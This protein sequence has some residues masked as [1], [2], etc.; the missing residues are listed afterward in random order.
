MSYLWVGI[1]AITALDLEALIR[2]KILIIK[3]GN[4]GIGLSWREELP[5]SVALGGAI[6]LVSQQIKGLKA[7]L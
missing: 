3:Q 7:S 5:E 4:G 6:L 1:A 2:S